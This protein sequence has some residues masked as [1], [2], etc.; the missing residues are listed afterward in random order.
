MHN[1]HIAT[2]LFIIGD[3]IKKHTSL[4]R[5]RPTYLILATS[6][7]ITLA[8]D[9]CRLQMGTYTKPLTQLRN[10]CIDRYPFACF[11]SSLNMRI[12]AIYK[13]I[14]PYN[15]AIRPCHFVIIGSWGKLIFQRKRL[16]VMERL[17]ADENLIIDSTDNMKYLPTWVFHCEFDK[18]HGGLNHRR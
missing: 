5:R 6:G 15:N 1:S 18:R 8:F 10:D 13:T 16:V 11:V 9:V 4:N 7:S 17:W 12:T 2:Y 14:V 3:T